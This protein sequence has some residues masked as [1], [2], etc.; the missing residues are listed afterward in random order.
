MMTT[1]LI[2]SSTA[3]RPSPNLH[4][5][6]AHPQWQTRTN[7][8]NEETLR[9]I[10][11]VGINTIFVDVYGPTGIGKG[12]FLAEKEGSWAGSSDE[13]QFAD[14]FSLDSL[15]KMAKKLSISVHVTIS[16]FGE[17]PAIDPTSQRHRRH[18]I[19]VVEYVLTRFPL[20]DGIHLDHIRYMSEW[21][22]EAN[23]NTEPITTFVKDVRQSIRGKVLSAAVLAV[24]D[25][26]EYDWA[27]SE[28]GQDCREMSRYL[29]FMCPMTYHLA[30]GKSLE[31]VESVTRF[32]SSIIQR[33]CR[34]YPTV[35]AYYQFESDTVVSDQ[36][37]PNTS[38]LGPSFEVPSIGMLQL[39]IKWQN[40]KN[41]F[42]IIVR[43]PLSREVFGNS[44][45]NYLRYSSAE[46]YLLNST[47]TGKWT[48]ELL[49]QSP[50][51]D[52]VVTL[53]VSDINEEFPGYQVL[54]SA[55]S[56]AMIKTD[57]FCVYALNNLSPKELEAIRDCVRNS[58]Y[59]TCVSN[60][61]YYLLA[62]NEI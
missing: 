10:A 12:I 57:G 18:L 9:Q 6:Y 55:I 41:S 61:N 43:D 11:Q 44:A 33:P 62:R 39:R 38:I 13:P 50:S 26:D 36:V 46:I 23:G 19:D 42:S 49:A 3:S 53:Q 5:V 28:T 48:T 51:E 60:H 24:G 25:Q 17:L 8:V 40:P 54:R 30:F 1:I 35:Q 14:T 7:Q 37:T 20:V 15:I 27:R 4:A 2:A 58:T 16:C 34:L 52:D 29:D 56:K 22:L 45:S 31:W 47:V 21:G 32:M 59:Q